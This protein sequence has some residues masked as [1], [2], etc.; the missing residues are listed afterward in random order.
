MLAC[1][2]RGLLVLRGVPG[3]R[4]SAAPGSHPAAAASGVCSLPLLLLL[5]SF[6]LFFLI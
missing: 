2:L 4:I 6:T 5:L 3:Y 1:V